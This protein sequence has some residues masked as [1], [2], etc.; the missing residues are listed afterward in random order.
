[1]RK[2][3][4]G[5]VSQQSPTP[6][7]DWLPLESLAEVEI[8]SEAAGHPIESALLPGGESGWRAEQPGEQVI[9]LKFDQ[10]QRLRR[11][12]LLF[13]EDERERTQEFVL[14]WLPEGGNAFRE[15]V[16]Q[17]WNFSPHG[18]TREAEDYRVDLSGVTQLELQIVPDISGGEAHA[19]LAQLRLA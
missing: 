15:L 18:S 12:W 8:T 17:Q 10:P 11:I 7:G 16:R 1:M 13:I 2:R 5:T 14:R 6:E 9:R 19:S 3:I 4:T